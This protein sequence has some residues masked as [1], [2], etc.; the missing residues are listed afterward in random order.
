[1]G[2]RLPVSAV[3]LTLTLTTMSAGTHGAPQQPAPA[4]ARQA[5][6]VPPLP[7]LDIG[8]YPATAREQIGPA[9]HVATAAPSDADAT[10]Q[11]GLV[12]HAWE[13][14][15]AAAQAYARAQALAP[16]RVDWWY[17]GALL[18]TRR[19][20]HADAARQFGQALE[21]RPDDPLIALRLADATLE[22]GRS[23]DAAR[24]YA[25]LTTRPETAPAAFYGLGRVKQQAGD[26][27]AAR[28]AFEQAVELYPDF[29]AA[30]Y[31]L[32]QLQRRAGDT[33]A[34]RASLQRQQQCLACW[35]VPPDPW[36]ARLDAVRD[37]APALLQRGVA[38]ASQ[39]SATAAAEAIRLHEAAVAR[40]PTLGQAHVNLI[41]LYAGTGNLPRAEQH[42][43]T[44][45]ALPGFAADAHRVWGWVLLQQRRPAEA[46]AALEAAT[47][48]TPDHAQ[49]QSGRGLA[50]EMLGRPADAV[51]AYR[52]AVAA[53][54]TARDIRFN[55]ARTLMTLNRLDEAITQ[56]D[57]VQQP[58]DAAT[59]RY[60]FALSVVHVRRG[61]LATGRRLGEEALALARRFDQTDLAQSIERDLAALARKAQ[62]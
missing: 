2:T 15:D 5:R 16:A 26:G 28:K 29:G 38:T 62:P 31:A 47:A 25:P 52:A 14:L 1:M 48:L 40:T 37:D 44:A 11:L 7:S 33:T 59:P 9:F 13:E 3:L 60:R 54:P 4:S 58:V 42:Y 12:L 50:L 27:D 8:A 17:Y 55:L 41:E 57:Q 24:L 36:R 51:E 21:R 34:A 39:G 49:A 56:L 32:A 43:Q 61:D 19:G 6:D 18:A 30:H 45:R 23:D 10:G 53:A 22:A 35:P 46:L 20:L